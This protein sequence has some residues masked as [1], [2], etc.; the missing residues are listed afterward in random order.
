MGYDIV[1]SELV[2]KAMQDSG[3]KNA[4]FAIAELIDNS[5][6]ANATVV[7][8]LCIEATEYLAARHRTRLRQL[9]VVDNGDGMDSD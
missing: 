7:E 1:P 8:L 9:A 3:Y 4:A 5:I 6:Q 2:V